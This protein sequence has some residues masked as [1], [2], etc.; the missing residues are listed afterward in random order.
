MAGGVVTYEVG[1]QQHV[2]FASGNVSRNAFGALGLPTVVVMSLNNGGSSAASAR[3]SGSSSAPAGAPDLAKGRKLYSQV[4][5]ACH[6][7]D[8]NLIANRKLGNLA[9]RRDLTQTIRYIKDPNPPMPKLFPD[10]I[11]EQGVVDVAAY[12]HEELSR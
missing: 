7:P 8:G 6:G 1:G 4:C 3:T 11:D 12:V 2:A 10:L 9:E 5:T